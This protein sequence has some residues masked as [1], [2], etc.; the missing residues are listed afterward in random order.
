MKGQGEREA[1]IQENKLKLQDFI[2]QKEANKL[3]SVGLP[4]KKTDITDSKQS[5]VQDKINMFNKKK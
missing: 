4:N 1:I 3:S 5:S 2:K